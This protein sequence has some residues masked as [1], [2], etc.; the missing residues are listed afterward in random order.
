[1]GLE[2]TT[3][4]LT[5]ERYYQLSYP[6][7]VPDLGQADITLA[8]DQRQAHRSG[9]DHRMAVGTEKN[10]LLS[11]RA[12]RRNASGEPALP[13]VES[14]RRRIEVVELKS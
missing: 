8:V 14:L 12:H 13:E 2:P 4:R 9:L 11:L 3:S 10:A 1:M 6:G 5:A 7:P